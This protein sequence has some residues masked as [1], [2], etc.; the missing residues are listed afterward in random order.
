MQNFIKK[1]KKFYYFKTKSLNKSILY[2][3]M[4]LYVDLITKNKQIW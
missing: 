3:I 1:H 4:L 2:V